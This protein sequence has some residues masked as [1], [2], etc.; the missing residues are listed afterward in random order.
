MGKGT[1][2]PENPEEDEVCGNFYR[3]SH[4]HGGN[5]FTEFG[6]CPDCG[7]KVSWASYP[8]I[9]REMEKQ[10]KIDK[11]KEKY[12]SDLRNIEEEYTKGEQ[13]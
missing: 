4:C 1:C 8:E 3:C 11:L 7:Y 6:Y 2:V 5:I 10:A 9:T 13:Q 12:N